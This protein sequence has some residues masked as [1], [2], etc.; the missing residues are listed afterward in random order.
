MSS[1]TVCQNAAWF[2]SSAGAPF[3]SSGDSSEAIC[4]FSLASQISAT[5]LHSGSGGS[6]DRGIRVSTSYRS[7]CGILLAYF[8][9]WTVSQ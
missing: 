2:G 8:T 4:S 6:P 7:I 5:P 3:I 9:A 1:T